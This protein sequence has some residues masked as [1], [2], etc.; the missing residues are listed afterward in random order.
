[1]KI[2]F[3]DIFPL[4][5]IL[6]VCLINTRNILKGAGN[7]IMRQYGKLTDGEKEHYDISKVKKS[8]MF[9]V[10]SLVIV[11]TFVFLFK[12]IFPNIISSKIFLVCFLI[13]IV[14]LLIFVNTRWIL[15][16]FC[17]K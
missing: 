6:I 7:T 10:L 12:F 16:W 11:I 17:K 4:L 9:Y 2:F 14:V 13:E 1:M 5:A 8:Q 15:N 3:Y